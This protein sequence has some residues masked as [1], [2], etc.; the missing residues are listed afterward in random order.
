[1]EEI[2]SIWVTKNYG[3]FLEFQFNVK[4]LIRVVERIIK[5]KRYY[6]SILFNVT[7]SNESMRYIYI[8]N[9]GLNIIRYELINSG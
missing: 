4:K 3:T 7:C 8:Y 2:E 6:K 5:I 1:M 9:K